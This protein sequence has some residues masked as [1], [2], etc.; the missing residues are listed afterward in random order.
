MS[1]LFD[2]DAHGVAVVGDLPT[3]L[4]DPA[5]PD[6]GVGDL[7]DLIAPALGVLVLTAEAIGVSRS[8]A[9]LHGYKVDANRDLAA[10]GASN[11][12][13]RP[14]LGLRPVGRREPDGGRR[15]RRRAHAARDR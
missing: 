1:A 9:T 13:R 11:L 4:P 15:G 12:A 7:V 6:V 8:L 5:L 14:R 2:L 10:L 3:A